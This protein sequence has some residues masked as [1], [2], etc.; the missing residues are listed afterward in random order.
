MTSPA[1]DMTSS[2][3]FVT[4]S[5]SEMVRQVGKVLRL[6]LKDCQSPE[7]LPIVQFSDLELDNKYKSCTCLP[8]NSKVMLR[9]SI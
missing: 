5:Q 8:L 9:Y 2:D 6:L 1:E 4:S 7:F 3:E